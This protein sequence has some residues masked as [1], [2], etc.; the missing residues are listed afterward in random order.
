MSLIPGL[1]SGDGSSKPKVVFFSLNGSSFSC[2]DGSSIFIKTEDL[3]YVK[4]CRGRLERSS[5]DVS[6]IVLF[7]CY[8]GSKSMTKSVFYVC[9]FSTMSF[10]LGPLYSPLL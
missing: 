8:Q 5:S 10:R 9:P 2:R 1:D 6:Y 3:L 4:V 7:M